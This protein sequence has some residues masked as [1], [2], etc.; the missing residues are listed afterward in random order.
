MNFRLVEDIDKKR[1]FM[2]LK[3]IDGEF[4]PPLHVRVDLDDYSSKLASNAVNLFLV[5]DNTDVA[6]AAF[7]CNDLKSKVSFISSIGL[8]PEFQG[9]GAAGYLLQKVIEKCSEK[10]MNLLR[11]EVDSQNL[12]AVKFYKRQGFRFVSN[13]LMEKDLAIVEYN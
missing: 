3:S 2:F 9:S 12:K 13:N 1:I 11:L 4:Y 7:Y 8:I 10:K 6:H 5:S